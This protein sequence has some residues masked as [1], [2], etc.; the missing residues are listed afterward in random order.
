MADHFV[1]STGASQDALY[2]VG[3]QVTPGSIA[4]LPIYSSAA[5]R[6]VIGNDGQLDWDWEGTLPETRRGLSG[7]PFRGQLY[8]VGGFPSNSDQPDR[9]LLTSY[10]EDDLTLHQFSFD[11]PGTVSGNSNFLKSEAL[12]VNQPR[13]SHA[14]VI[15]AADATSANSAFIYVLGGRGETNPLNP[16]DQTNAALDSVIFGKIGGSEDVAVTG[17]ASDGWYYSKPFPINITNAQLKEISWA[18][19]IDRT[20]APNADIRVD[21]RVSSADTCDSANWTESSWLEHPLDGSPDDAFNSVPG[22]N[23][24]NVANLAARCFQYRAKLSTDNFQVT[25]SLLNLSIEI[26]VP[27][28]PDLSVQTLSAQYSGKLFT[29]LNVVIQN[30]N[31]LV[32]PALKADIE[33]GGSFAVDLC[34]Y[35]PNVSGPAPILPLTLA[36]KGC[37]TANRQ[38]DK[39]IMGPNASY[40]VTGWYDTVT[41]QPINLLEYFRKPGTYTVYA[42]VDSTVDDPAVWPRG[43][44]DEGDG[45]LNPGENN[46]VSGPITFSVQ[47]VGYGLYL[48]HIRR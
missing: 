8:A 10:V 40:S 11:P 28:N 38:V 5:Y 24:A 36:N 41:D 48:P 30:V 17:Y 18:T 4:E 42:A 13:A 46:N 23:A 22:Q 21:F 44:V 35:G 19:V 34:I 29:G 7:V 31:L 47:A 33:R 12:P 25:P 2:V 3:G 45:A 39:A 32:P 16:N 20:T 9:G 26:F 27:G 1:A 37:S 14:T 6:A 43:Y 15:V